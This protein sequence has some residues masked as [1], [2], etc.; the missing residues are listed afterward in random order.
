MYPGGAAS[1]PSVRSGSG[2]AAP[3]Q[4]DHEFE[5]LTTRVPRRVVDA[6]E[7]IARNEEETRST[8]VRRLLRRALEQEHV[9]QPHVSTTR[10]AAR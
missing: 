2:M 3:T 8:I 10:R 5:I 4:T 7:S 9:D 6:I 1:L